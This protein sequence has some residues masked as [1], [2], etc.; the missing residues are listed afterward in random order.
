MLYFFLLLYIFFE[1][2][3]IFIDDYQKTKRGWKAGDTEAPLMLSFLAAVWLLFLFV[4]VTIYFCK[5]TQEMIPT[6][7]W[8]RTTFMTYNFK[9]FNGMLK[10]P[11]MRVDNYCRT[12]AGDAYGLYDLHADF[13]ERTR[14]IENVKDAGTII[15]SAA[16]DKPEDQWVATMLHEMIH[17]YIYLVVGIY[18]NDQH[19]KL[20]QTIASRMINDGFDVMNGESSRGAG[21]NVPNSSGG[22]AAGAATGAA[23]GAAAGNTGGSGAGANN[24]KILCLIY[25]PS[26]QNYKYWCTIC[27]MSEANRFYLKANGIPGVTGVSFYKCN[28]QNINS[29]QTDYNTLKG[30]GAMSLG[31]LSRN[32]SNYFQENPAIFDF[33]RIRRL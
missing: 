21:G 32:M 29:F 2:I 19:G 3:T 16:Y 31:E 14:L 4:H 26:G 25:K 12:D 33:T 7:D 17:E 18:P 11:Q 27:E 13:N 28:S 20:F 30:F 22:G 15:L 5:K 9:Y 6:E 1:K 23:A 8:M 10:E 24:Q